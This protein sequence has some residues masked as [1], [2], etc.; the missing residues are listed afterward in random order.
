MLVQQV[1]VD[2]C[3]DFLGTLCHEICKDENDVLYKEITMLQQE[4]MKE[5]INE[6]FEQSHHNE[7]QALEN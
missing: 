3:E 6:G 5:A 4:K 7:E 1:T 2:T